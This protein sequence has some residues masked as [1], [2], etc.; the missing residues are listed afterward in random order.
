[1]ASVVDFPFN[2]T[3]ASYLALAT[4]SKRL[5]GINSKLTPKIALKKTMSFS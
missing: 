5:E 4:K 2:D 3:H 1:M